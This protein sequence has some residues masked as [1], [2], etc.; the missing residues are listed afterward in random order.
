MIGNSNSSFFARL[1]RKYFNWRLQREIFGGIFPHAGGESDEGYPFADYEDMVNL[2]D[3]FQIKKMLAEVES[4]AARLPT[5]YGKCF[6]YIMCRDIHQ[7]L[8]MYA[9]VAKRRAV[10]DAAK[11]PVVVTA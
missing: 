2:T 5:A 3:S 8:K 1:R 6:R 9:D 4:H 7:R 11:M 10:P